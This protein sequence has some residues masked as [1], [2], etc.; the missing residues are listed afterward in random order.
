MNSCFTVNDLICCK[1]GEFEHFQGFKELLE[2][3]TITEYSQFEL[4]ST[5]FCETNGRG[6]RVVYFSIEAIALMR[7]YHTV[8]KLQINACI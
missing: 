4:S 5:E 6:D 7:K 8:I 3:K 1:V 2:K